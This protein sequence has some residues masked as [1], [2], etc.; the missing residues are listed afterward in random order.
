MK[1]F[2]PK[3][4]WH[5]RFVLYSPLQK[6]HKYTSQHMAVE[7]CTECSLAGDK[8]RKNTKHQRLYAMT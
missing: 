2:K 4:I 3:A 1:M 7:I 8:P 6:V 5:K